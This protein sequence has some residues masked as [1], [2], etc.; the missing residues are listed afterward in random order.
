MNGHRKCF[1]DILKFEGSAL[2][3]HVFHKHL[4][5][6]DDKLNNFKLGIVKEVSPRL[7]DRTE[8]FY[9]YSTRAETQSLNRIK[10]RR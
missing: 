8:D 9:V 5:H 6:F 10:V 4:E 3:D 7:L 2:S 1:N